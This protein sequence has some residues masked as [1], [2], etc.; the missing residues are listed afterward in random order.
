MSRVSFVA[1]ASLKLLKK[2]ARPMMEVVV[3][4]AMLSRE[5]CCRSLPGDWCRKVLSAFLS[6]VRNVMEQIEILS[7]P[8]PRVSFP[9]PRSGTEMS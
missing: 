3:A 4:M 8:G 5:F 7:S 2:V 1:L 9:I 6:C